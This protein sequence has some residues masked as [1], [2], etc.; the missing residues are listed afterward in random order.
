MILPTKHIPPENSLLG[1]GA[2]ILSRLRSPKTTS[3]LWQETRR[4]GAI[5]SFDRYVL[6]LDLLYSMGLITYEEGL[7]RRIK[8]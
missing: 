5:A 3:A 1:H 8:Q 6:T 4:D 2:T 7:L